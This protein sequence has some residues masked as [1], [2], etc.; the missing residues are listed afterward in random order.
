MPTGRDREMKRERERE[1]REIKRER[2]TEPRRRPRL[3][4]RIL[5]G[6]RQANG[7][8]QQSRIRF[9]RD[10]VIFGGTQIQFP[11]NQRQIGRLRCEFR[12]SQWRFSVGHQ[13]TISP[14]DFL[15]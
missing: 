2:E 3:E 11:A 1:I 12:S 13:R 6:R 4:A 9:R 10:R 15:C 7:V 8:V 5:V 14:V